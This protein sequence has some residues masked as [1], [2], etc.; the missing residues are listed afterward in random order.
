MGTEWRNRPMGLLAITTGAIF[1]AECAVMALLALAPPLPTVVEA[2]LDAL[3][4]S[5]LSFPVLYLTIFRPALRRISLGEDAALSRDR[6]GGAVHGAAGAVA[7]SA[8]AL[9]GEAE[10]SSGAAARQSAGVE[11][12]AAALDELQRLSASVAGTARS[13]AERSR[14]SV[15]T[16]AAGRA[17]VERT[18]SA[19]VAARQN[20]DE[21]AATTTRLVERLLEVATIA[22][23]V[24]ELAGH[25]GVLA[26]NAAMEAARAGDAGRGFAVV[27]TEVRGLADRSRQATVEIRAVLRDLTGMGRAA[28]ERAQEVHRTVAGASRAAV[29]AD[30]TI[31]A[32]LEAIAAAEADLAAVRQVADEHVRSVGDIHATA[33]GIAAQASAAL[34]SA[35]QIEDAARSLGALSQE[36]D[37]Q[38][39]REVA[40]A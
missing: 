13:V 22:G 5:L 7:S 15:V 37:A 3:L 27:A 39:S 8:A 18:T 36:L 17:A 30:A 6:L 11:R 24:D 1:A 19:L 25:T 10:R 35:R 33:R 2:L 12:I 20:V 16:G 28:I 32:L 40:R 31:A 9:L 38:L 29:E 34:G 4:L 26:L 14:E 23:K 21:A